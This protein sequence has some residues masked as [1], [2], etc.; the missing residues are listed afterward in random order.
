MSDIA[1]TSL[2]DVIGQR[3]DGVVRFHAVPYTQPPLGAL[4]FAPPQPPLPWGSIDSRQPGPIAPQPPSRLRLAMGDFNREQS[5]D[6]LT[7][8]IATPGAD[9]AK[10]P[11]IVWLHGGAFLSGGGSLPWYDGG[12]LAATGDAVVVGV[13]YRLGPLGYLYW[14]GLGDGL[15]G[16]HDMVAALRFVRDHIAAFGGDPDNVTV[17]GQSAGAVAILR[18]LDRDDTAGL[19]HRAIVQSG[20]PRRGHDRDT[21]IL[22]SKRLMELLDIDPAGPDVAERLR[23]VP[24]AQLATL[25][26]QIARENAR[27]AAIDPAFP[28][29]FDDN[30]DG[31]AFA[32]RVAA[33]CAARGVDIAIGYTREEMGAFFTADPAMGE[34]DPAAVAERFEA[35]TGSADTIALYR[36]RRPGG[37]LR[38]LLGDMITDQ[39]FA[40]PAVG[41]A[42][43]LH[44]VG[45]PAYLYLFDWAAPGSTWGSCHCI[46]LP[47][48]FGNR[49]AWDAPM[50]AGMNEAEYAGLSGTMMAVWASFARCGDPSVPDLAW[51]V[52]E[53]S[54]RFGP[55]IGVEGDWA[56]VDR[57]GVLAAA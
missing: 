34:P 33:A 4:R 16:I 51:P 17:M 5:E 23:A 3:A 6:C 26:M 24:A 22:R 14:P 39:R 52:Y 50:L 38:E 29:V 1:H 8:L 25:Q 49:A 42:E 30:G 53:P 47:F 43:K 37:G 19:F 13:N 27:F 9:S 54:R 7:L 10:R 21:A 35:L 44:A 46:D 40:F 31:D 57:R 45:R 36:R 56:T 15:M 55:V 48:V 11:V 20:P 2:G 41:L 32:T 18:L 12:K 28:P